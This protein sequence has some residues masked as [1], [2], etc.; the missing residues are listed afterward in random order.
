M[1]RCVREQRLQVSRRAAGKN[2]LQ[3][4]VRIFRDS[5]LDAAP[6]VAVSDDTDANLLAHK[7]P[8]SFTKK[9]V[10]AHTAAERDGAK[11]YTIPGRMMHLSAQRAVFRPVFVVRFAAPAV[12]FFF[13][14]A[15][16]CPPGCAGPLMVRRKPRQRCTCLLI[17]AD[18]LATN[19]SNDI[20]PL[21][22]MSSAC[23]Q[24]AVVPGSAMARGTASIRLNAAG[25]A[26]RALPC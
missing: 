12:R 7:S 18:C 13:Q 22:T 4:H 20:S 24:I 5:G 2:P 25:L 10:A 21:C 9:T 23:S 6:Q 19:S 15:L 3:R 26:A 8:F 11:L 17:H 16:P 14:G 1:H